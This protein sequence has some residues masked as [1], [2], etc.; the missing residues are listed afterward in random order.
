MNSINS[1][2][3]HDNLTKEWLCFEKAIK[4]YEVYDKYLL[5][6]T[7]SEIENIVHNDDLY[8]A[9]FLSYEAASGINP[10]LVTQSPSNFPLC[11]FGIYE[12]PSVVNPPETNNVCQNLAWQA[13]NS[14][15]KYF[16][17]INRIREQIREGETY[18][19]NYSYRLRSSMSCSAWDIFANMVL[20]QGHGYS[21]YVEL[22]D[23]SICS[24]SPEIFFSLSNQE[25]YCRPMKGTVS[26]GLTFAS[27]KENRSW[28][29]N[30]SKD[31]AENL[32]ILDM[33]RNDLGQIASSGTVKVDS[34]FDMEKYPTVWQMTSNVHCHT[35][36]GLTEIMQS[37][38]PAASITGAPKVH[39]MEIIKELECSPRNIYTGTIG[40][41]SPA[42]RAQ[43]N[44]AIR[45]L[46]VDKRNQ[47]AEYGIGSGIV[48]DSNGKNEFQETQ[49]KASVLNFPYQKFSL[50]ESLFWDPDEGF[51]LLSE[52]FIRIKDS[53]EYFSRPYD[54]EK[55][56][57]QLNTFV[58]ELDS[59][60]HKIRVLV[61]Q[62][63]E[64]EIQ[65]KSID[66]KSSPLSIGLAKQSINSNNIFLYHKTTNRQIY[67]DVLVGM[68]AYD[69]V[70][71]WNSNNEVTETSTSN[72]VAEIEGDLYTP[73]VTC[74]LLAGT[75]RAQLLREGKI[76]ERVIQID[77][78][79]D[80]TKYYLINS[81]QGWQE[82][83]S[84]EIR[85]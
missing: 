11:W 43:F 24:A 2:I 36:S 41:Y 65:A 18:Q 44:V 10:A 50:L 77:E 39:T 53:A 29:A 82:V 25:I 59:V 42:R 37:L 23:W 62:N 63:G 80:C 16:S 32:M 52:H 78:I 60:A 26:R 1:I 5:I 75:Y 3:L 48:W 14:Q 83:K 35:D 6:E 55:L 61:D 45:T 40:Y 38:Y 21:A 46:L 66:K 22:A 8:A 30:S 31:R 69:D 33:V 76:K 79:K 28:L 19:V 68:S 54:E 12:S 67:D 20:A 51:W 9:G 70:L 27:D 4:V 47:Q 72:F 64:I 17:V 15:E 84:L 7:L 85:C 73:P 57:K 56:I 58:T 74:G 13:S 71:L 34:L 49:D 81:V